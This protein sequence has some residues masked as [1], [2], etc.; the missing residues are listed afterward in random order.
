MQILGG[1]R[2]LSCW[3]CFGGLSKPSGS[4][5][6]AFC[7]LEFMAGEITGHET[8]Y[9]FNFPWE[10]SPAWLSNSQPWSRGAQNGRIVRCPSHTF[11]TLKQMH[12]KE[13][14]ACTGNR[15]YW[16]ISVVLKKEKE[17]RKKK[18]ALVFSLSHGGNLVWGRQQEMQ[19][20]RKTRNKLFIINHASQKTI[21]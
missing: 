6:S 3:P 15:T 16:S 17:E 4:D 13:K 18:K 7:C 1:S 8:V 2:C 10:T 9:Q 20:F 21:Q 19:N 12:W 5:G 14:R 11:W